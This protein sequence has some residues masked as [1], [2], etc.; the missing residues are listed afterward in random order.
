VG[1]DAFDRF[2][3]PEAHHRHVSVFY[4]FPS[5]RLTVTM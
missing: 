2:I 1:R 4:A 3:G 5:D